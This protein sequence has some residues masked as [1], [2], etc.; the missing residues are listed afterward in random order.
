M[1]GGRSSGGIKNLTLRPIGI[2]HTDLRTS[3]PGPPVTP[4]E[5]RAKMAASPAGHERGRVEVFQEFAAG[6][7]DVED[8]ERP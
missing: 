1:T 6:L 3:A 8:Y 2:I 5:L 7:A 4:D